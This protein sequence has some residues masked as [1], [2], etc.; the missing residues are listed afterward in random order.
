[1]FFRK[2]FFYIEKNDL[3][4]YNAGV[5]AVKLKVIGLAPGL[6]PQF[7]SVKCVC[8]STCFSTSGTDHTLKISQE[9]IYYCRKFVQCQRKQRS[10]KMEGFLVS[11]KWRETKSDVSIFRDLGGNYIRYKYSLFRYILDIYSRYVFALSMFY[12]YKFDISILALLIYCRY[13]FDISIFA[14]STSA[15]F[16]SI[17]KSLKSF[18]AALKILSKLGRFKAIKN[19]FASRNN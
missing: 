2:V 4:Y 8:V 15:N 11:R 14:L 19:I 9:I 3:A 7:T 13:K 5:V 18:Q 6:N 12:R 1:V 17:E 16:G 10:A